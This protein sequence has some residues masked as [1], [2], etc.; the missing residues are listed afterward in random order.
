MQ[1]RHPE[2][3]K[4]NRLYL[5]HQLLLISGGK[6]TRAAPPSKINGVN[7]RKIGVNGM[8]TPFFVCTEIFGGKLNCLNYD[9]DDLFDLYDF[10][11]SA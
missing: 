7:G 1:V 10:F 3:P 6:S 11:R 8:L 9:L 5:N 2:N 4:S